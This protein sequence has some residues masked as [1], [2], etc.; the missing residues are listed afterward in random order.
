M[1][2]RSLID[3]TKFNEWE[4]GGG[5]GGDSEMMFMGHLVDIFNRPFGTLVKFSN[6]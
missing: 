2:E 3:L 4:G 5:G 1:V 6:S